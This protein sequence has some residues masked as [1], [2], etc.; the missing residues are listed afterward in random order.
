MR[1][2][3]LLLSTAASCL[4]NPQVIAFERVEAR[5][6]YDAMLARMDTNEDKQLSMEEIKAID[7][8]W[9]TDEVNIAAVYNSE[10]TVN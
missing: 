8:E 3:L 1:L 5:T 4:A 10:A 7:D 6:E 2:L 9:L